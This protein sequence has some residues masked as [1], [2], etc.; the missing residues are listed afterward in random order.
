MN[1]PVFNISLSYRIN[2]YRPTRS[3][4]GQAPGTGGGGDDMGGGED[5]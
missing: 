1:S 3:G 4:K 2:N 5:F